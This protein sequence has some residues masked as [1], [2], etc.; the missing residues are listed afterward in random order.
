[1]QETNKVNEA[2]KYIQTEN[3]SQ[4]NTLILAG[5]NVVA[6]Q[7]NV[8]FKKRKNDKPWW[9]RR[10]ENQIADIRRDISKIF[11]WR[12]HKLKNENE[13][14]RL[15][16]KYHVINKGMPAIIEELKQRVKANTAKIRKY[17]DRN[18]QYLQNRLYETNRKRL[19]ELIEG[20]DRDASIKPDAEES[21][22][23]WGNIWGK[24]IKHNEEAEWLKEV[25]NTY[26]HTIKQ[27]EIKITII[28]L[29]KQI[30]KIPKWKSAGPDGVHG[31]WIKAFNKLHEEIALYLDQILISGEVPIW[32][33]T[34]N[35]NLILKDI[36]KGNIVSNF[37]PI[38]CLPMMWKVLAGVIA[39]SLYEHLE[40][41][42]IIPAEQK[43]CKR[44]SRGTKDQLLIDKMVLKNCKKRLTNLCISWIDY[45]KAY[46]MIPHSWLI[47][48]MEIFNLAENSINLLKNSMKNWKVNLKC[49]EELL[50][51]VD[52]KRGIFQG[53]SLSPI[54][55]VLALIPLSAV[56][57]KMKDGYN[58]G[59]D[60]GK[61]NHLLFMDDLKLY[62]KDM[63]E[64]DSLVQSVR[65]FSGDIGME[66]SIEKC[67]VLAIKRG[68]V[69]ESVGI[70]LPNGETI[71]SLEDDKGYKYLGILES[72]DIKSNEMKGIVRK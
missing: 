43:G 36:S 61:I 41:S 40:N 62:G 9:K 15:N 57:R 10:I 1:M 19:Y 27:E 7:L 30:S 23:F 48:C 16:R 46:D 6:D 26:R 12:E 17:E 29:K 28:N 37:R 47:K 59:R 44:N 31:Y 71:K 68:K 56:L 45:K 42:S 65:V 72:D 54:L 64:L 14:N 8:K 3:I 25:E 22:K 63:V 34:G 52:I 60:R 13:K 70:D 39:N 4:I 50:G 24:E 38:T 49:G 58:L 51:N 66:F 69:V 67:A 20:E 55:F 18:N 21:L 35:T 32:M 11:A 2:L 5:A 33:T 53:D